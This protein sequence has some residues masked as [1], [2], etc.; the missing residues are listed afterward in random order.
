MQRRLR[1]IGDVAIIVL[2]A[3]AAHL[4]LHAYPNF[5]SWALLIQLSAFKSVEVIERSPPQT[6]QLPDGLYLDFVDFVALGG[7]SEARWRLVR[8]LQFQLF[9]EQLGV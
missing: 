3:A 4:V 2:L 5:R 7:R 1:A 9:N 6:A 8:Q